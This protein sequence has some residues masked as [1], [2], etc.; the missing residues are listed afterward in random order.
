MKSIF[1]Q[2]AAASVAFG[3]TTASAHALSRMPVPPLSD[4]VEQAELVFL[5]TLIERAEDGEWVR[6]VLR[7]DES[8]RVPEG[9]RRVEVIWRVRVGD[10]EVYDAAEGQRGVAILDDKHEGRYWLRTDKFEPA[11]RLGEVRELVSEAPRKDV[12]TFEQWVADE[13]PIPED[14]VFTGGTP[15]FDETTGQRRNPRE[16]YEMVHGVEAQQEKRRE[17]RFPEHW[18]EPPS[19]QTRDL[20]PLPGGYGMGSGTLARW[21]QENM[22]RDAEAGNSEPSGEP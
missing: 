22:E 10:R 4:R 6:A 18:G 15:W 1:H 14:M 12:P 9:M 17:R 2:I 20:R 8:L 7:V 19:R 16:V 11:E 5:G 3:I 21:I 13:M